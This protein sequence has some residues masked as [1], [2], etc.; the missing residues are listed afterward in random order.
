MSTRPQGIRPQGIRP[1]GIRPLDIRPLGTRWSIRRLA[2]AALLAGG[3][4]AAGVGA[5]QAHAFL[6]HAVP[7]VGST[8]TASPPE[9]TLDYTEGIEPRFS[10]VDVLDAQ[11]QHVDAGDLHLAPDNPKRLVIGLKKLGPGTYTVKWHVTSVDT[12]H[13]EGTFSFSVQP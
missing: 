1:Q 4:V 13:T 3:A 5:A 8:L 12:H 11:G 9:M 10:G 6:R 2:A 7:A